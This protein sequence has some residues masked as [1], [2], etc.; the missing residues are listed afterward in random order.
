[1]NAII[2]TLATAAVVLAPIV[3][4]AAPRN[5]APAAID[6]ARAASPAVAEVFG[7][8]EGFAARLDRAERR[9][10]SP[11]ADGLHASIDRAQISSGALNRVLSRG[12][13]AASTVTVVAQAGR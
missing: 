3:A 4:H 1:M 8:T 13:S 5:D 12:P 10:A 6:A 11:S 9:L 7:D 2:R